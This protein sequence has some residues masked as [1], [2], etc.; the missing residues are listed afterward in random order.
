[1]AAPASSLVAGLLADDSYLRRCAVVAA[2]VARQ[3]YAV[4]GGQIAGDPVNPNGADTSAR[5]VFAKR[6]IA[7]TAP[8]PAIARIASL[9]TS[10]LGTITANPNDPNNAVTDSALIAAVQSSFTMLSNSGV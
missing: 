9:D 7:G 8:A 3:I 4:N 1:M 10:V 2:L 6:C 5:L